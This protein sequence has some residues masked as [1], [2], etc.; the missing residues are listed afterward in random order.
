MKKTATLLF[1]VF[2]LL[3]TF[4][5]SAQVYKFRTTDYTFR[6]T[7]T[8][9]RGSEWAPWEEVNALITID[10]DESRIHIYTKETQVYDIID[11]NS[12]KTKNENDITLIY[13]CIDKGGSSCTIKLERLSYQN[14]QLFLSIIYP[15]YT[16]VYVVIFLD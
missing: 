11:Y 12:P 15:G 5:A 4:S 6:Q 7:L 3:M 9:S 10:T 1:I 2:A 14:N 16:V 8:N 13:S